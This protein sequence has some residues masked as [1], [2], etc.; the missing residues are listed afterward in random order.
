MRIINPNPDDWLQLLRQAAKTT[1]KQI[2]TDAEE[3]IVYLTQKS[4]NDWGFWQKRQNSRVTKE[5][6]LRRTVE[7][8]KKKAG[9]FLHRIED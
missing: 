1:P 3:V 5:L 4:K 8:I 6:V 2:L 7:N 9:N